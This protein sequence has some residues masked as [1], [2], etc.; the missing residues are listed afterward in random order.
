M[1]FVLACAFIEEQHD[2]ELF[3]PAMHEYV[4]PCLQLLLDHRGRHYAR[5]FVAMKHGAHQRHR[6][7]PHGAAAFHIYLDQFQTLYWRMR[8]N[9]TAALGAFDQLLLNF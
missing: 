5:A 2:A 6:I 1:M 7:R 8:R 4:R 3:A 9:S